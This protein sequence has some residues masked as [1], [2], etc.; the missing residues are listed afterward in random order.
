MTVFHFNSRTALSWIVIWSMWIFQMV[1]FT[2]MHQVVLLEELDQ[3]KLLLHL[4]K[5]H[6]FFL[7][8]VYKT[9]LLHLLAK[10]FSCL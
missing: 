8:V 9:Q 1:D 7:H 5:R 4:C 3:F 10:N 2:L 6:V